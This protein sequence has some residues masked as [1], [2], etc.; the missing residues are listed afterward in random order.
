LEPLTLAKRLWLPLFL[1]L[2]AFYLFGLGSLPLV[3]PDEPR[4]VEVAREMFLRRDW[5]TPTL[6]GHTWFEKPV[7]L[8]WTIIASFKLFG[9]S[10]W[11]ARLGS[12]LSG[13]FTI[14][15][16]WWMSRRIEIQ[17]GRTGIAF[18]NT[19]VIAS[20]G[21]LIFFSRAASFDIGLTM[22]VAWALAFFLV[23]ETSDRYKTR[24][25]AGFYCFIGLSLLAKGLIGIILPF[26]VIGL[27]YLLRRKLPAR[28]FVLSLLWGVPLAVAIAAVWYGPVIARHGWQF[29]DQFFIQH[30]FA[31][32]FSNKY[33]HR[34]PFY[35]YLPVILML[36]LPW[37]VFL[38]ESLV[39]AKRWTWKSDDPITTM[40]L[41]GLAWLLFPPL[42]FSFSGSKLPGYVLPALPAVA[43]LIG[44]RLSLEISRVAL[45]LTAVL[46]TGG[47][48]AAI[49]YAQ[50]SHRVPFW[51]A[52]AFA[53]PLLIVGVVL[54]V[55]FGRRVAGLVLATTALLVS[56]IA[57][58]CG[59]S[60]LA[61]G[62]SVRDLIRSADSE[63]FGKSSLLMY[64]RVERSSEFYAAGRV[65]YGTDGEPLKFESPAEVVEQVRKVHKPLLMIVPLGSWPQ[66]QNID[67]T[68]TKLIAENGRNGIVVVIPDDSRSPL[69]P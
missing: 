47:G 27:F 16:V 65:V 10:E 31:R 64:S 49:V 43:L 5:I 20:M 22:T 2:I 41:F 55:G 57:L 58:S 21:G 67:G 48:L 13:I 17:T 14:V 8:Y 45:R 60:S 39:Q 37:S 66:V 50:V 68:A 1:V 3:G 51:C 25:L 32:Y 6:G 30:H 12:A 56:L 69:R 61:A 24:L 53:V 63:G 4:Y 59:A 54:V 62:E 28:R 46:L 36:V 40:R 26:G 11:S 29:I 18:A 44:D 35:F 52:I 19:L 9:V 23:Y 15:A 7:L 42:F 33:Q 34:Q 38:V